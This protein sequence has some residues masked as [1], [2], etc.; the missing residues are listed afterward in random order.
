M[1]EQQMSII[2]ANDDGLQSLIEKV[3]KNELEK[4]ANERPEMISVE[5]IKHESEP[6]N[7]VSSSK[8]PESTAE[9]QTTVFSDTTESENLDNETISPTITPSAV[10]NSDEITAEVETTTNDLQSNEDEDDDQISDSL[11]SAVGDL[12][13]S[14]LG[15]DNSDEVK[16]ESV[17]SNK[18]ELTT[19]SQQVTTTDEILEGTDSVSE[20]ATTPAG[21][22]GEESGTTEDTNANRD[23]PTNEV[24]EKIENLAIAQTSFATENIPEQVTETVSDETTPEV[25]EEI[26]LKAEEKPDSIEQRIT[27]VM[28]LVK[29]T[30]GRLALEAFASAL[31]KTL[32][33]KEMKNDA[34]DLAQIVYGTLKES[35]S[36]DFGLYGDKSEGFSPAIHEDLKNFELGFNDAAVDANHFE[37]ENFLPSLLQ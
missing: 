30:E 27:Q 9:P 5:I 7:V 32:I 15:I 34:N 24:D 33:N 18:S 6:L 23:K 10:E 28:N 13:S 19:Q 4:L 31:D 36:S 35:E 22:E 26:S 16:S 3:V 12:L 17:D 29:G 25:M 2:K 11:L 20:A 21:L 14:I 8:E 1:T 37:H